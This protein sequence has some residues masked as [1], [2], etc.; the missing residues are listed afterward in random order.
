MHLQYLSAAWNNALIIIFH[1]LEA[2]MAFIALSPEE[3][4]DL[5]NILRT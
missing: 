5:T 3:R 2:F 4:S 1:I